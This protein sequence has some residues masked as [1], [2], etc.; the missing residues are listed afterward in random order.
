MHRGQLCDGGLGQTSP[1]PEA[2]CIVVR[3][4]RLSVVSLLRQNIPPS[5]GQGEIVGG[6]AGGGKSRAKWKLPSVER[7]VRVGG[8]KDRHRIR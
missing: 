7:G 8:K 5:K 1:D 4:A 2:N 6:L 3:A